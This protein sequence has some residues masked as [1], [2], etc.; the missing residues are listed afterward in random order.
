MRKETGPSTGN[1][2]KF[3]RAR[4]VH[5]PRPR[6][7]M[8]TFFFHA[9]MRNIRLWAVEGRPLRAVSLRDQQIRLTT[10]GNKRSST[11]II[12]RFGTLEMH[13]YLVSWR[14][15]TPFGMFLRV[16]GDRPEIDNTEM[17][18]IFRI[19]LKRLTLVF[20]V[21]RGSQAFIVE[22]HKTN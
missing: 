11:T 10:R 3:D 2:Y 9:T 20:N 1:R 22:V 16:S 21:K 4:E 13:R 5:A 6:C 15:C 18:A 8:S 14:Q 12:G 17:T 7:L 19:P